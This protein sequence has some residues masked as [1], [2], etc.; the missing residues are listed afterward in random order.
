MVIVIV[1]AII[2]PLVII[3]AIVVL[4][5]YCNDCNIK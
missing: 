5:N 3:I 4:N 2:K 1:T